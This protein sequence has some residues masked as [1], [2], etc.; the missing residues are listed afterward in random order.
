MK[1]VQTTLS[2]SEY[3]EFERMAKSLNLTLKNATREAIRGWIFQRGKVFIQGVGEEIFSHPVFESWQKYFVE[4]YGP[5]ENKILFFLNC[6]WGKPY[7]ESW[8]FKSISKAIQEVRNLEEFHFI[9]VSSAGLVP[10]EY[11]DYYPFNSYD[12]DPWKFSPQ[13]R[14]SYVEINSKRVKRYLEKH[15]KAYERILVFLPEKDAA[16]IAVEKGY[17]NSGCKLD[18]EFVDGIFADESNREEDY[19]ACLTYKESL[20]KLKRILEVV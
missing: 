12:A 10:R 19:Y 14:K 6:T 16:R 18:I 13:D 1:N 7:H 20:L 11:W 8:I 5:P 9:V 2:D 17:E 4:D 3:S 15:Q